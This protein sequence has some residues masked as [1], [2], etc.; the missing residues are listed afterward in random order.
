MFGTLIDYWY[1]TGD[2]TYNDVV[3]QGLQ[4]QVG[5]YYDYMPPNQTKDEGNDDQLFWAFSVMSAA[6]YK[7]PNPPATMPGWVAMAQAVFNSQALR[8]DPTT[9]GGGMHWQI[10]QFNNGWDYKNSPSNAGFMNLGARLY[11]YTDNSTY[12]D[13]VE[14]MWNWLDVGTGVGLISAEYDVYDGTTPSENCT[15]LDHIQWTYSA[16]MALN[17]AATMWNK[18]QSQ[19]WRDRAEGLWN[20]SAEI[21]FKDGVMYEVACEPQNN[22]DTD[23]LRYAPKYSPFPKSRNH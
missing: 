3:S 21:F 7:F 5:P 16:G 17:A 2:T 14:K 9:C 18:T 23:Q 13:W 20:R 12:A 15:S 19:T 8:W 4:F 11:A 1:Y 10:F 22:C 6:E